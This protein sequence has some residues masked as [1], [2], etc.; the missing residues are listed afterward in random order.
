MK[1]S[2]FQLVPTMSSQKWLQAQQW[3]RTRGGVRR[4]RRSPEFYMATLSKGELDSATVQPFLE[5]I[6]GENLCKTIST[7]L[8]ARDLIDITE[9]AVTQLFDPMLTHIHMAH[10]TSLSNT[11]GESE[12][13]STVGHPLSACLGQHSSLRQRVRCA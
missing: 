5:A 10:A 7:V 1:F 2:T 12:G 13:S 3:H 8:S 11:I 4:K 6:L 9:L